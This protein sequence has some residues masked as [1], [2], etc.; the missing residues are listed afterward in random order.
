MAWEAAR[1]GEDG[2][3]LRLAYIGGV[4]ADRADVRWNDLHLTVTLSRMDTPSDHQKLGVIH[5]CVELQLSRDASDRLLVDGKTG[6]LATAK[7][8][9]YLNDEELRATERTWDMV[10][11]PHEFLEPREFGP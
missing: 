9:R 3:R 7:R 4:P 2:T 1:F 8:S 10:F 5:H 6:E 11:E